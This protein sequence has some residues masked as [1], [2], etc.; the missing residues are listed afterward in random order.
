M[1]AVVFR[2]AAQSEASDAQDWYEAEAVGLGARFRAEL[3]HAAQRLAANPLQFP[4]VLAAQW[5]MISGG[6]GWPL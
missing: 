5:L 3:D 4:L 1:H 6:K 2:P